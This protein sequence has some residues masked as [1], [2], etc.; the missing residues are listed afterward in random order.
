MLSLVKIYVKFLR[1]TRI[2]LFKY[3][4][5]ARLR[6]NNVLK[7]AQI[8]YITRTLENADRIQLNDDITMV[9]Y[10]KQTIAS[11]ATHWLEHS[12]MTNFLR[13]TDNSYTMFRQ[14]VVI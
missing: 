4:L 6:L 10:Q 1:Y 3:L 13:S 5:C 7:A 12:L 11:A 8:Y 14:R 9:I 2:T